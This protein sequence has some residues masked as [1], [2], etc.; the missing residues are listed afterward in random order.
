MKK[1]DSNEQAV[2]DKVK[3]MAKEKNP[4]DIAL[5]DFV[6]E[7]TIKRWF[8]KNLKQV[9]SH[10]AVGDIL[11]RLQ[12]KG[13]ITLDYSMDNNPKTRIIINK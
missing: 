11:K 8:P 12:K 2:L 7:I 10:T 9:A 6:V 5:R 3:E 13:Y 4:V 1:L